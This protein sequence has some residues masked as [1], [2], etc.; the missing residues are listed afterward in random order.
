MESSEHNSFLCLAMLKK[1]IGQKCL[2]IHEN[3]YIISKACW[4]DEAKTFSQHA[5]QIFLNMF[6]STPL[7]K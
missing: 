2:Q 5:G 3:M 7:K 4:K 6:V 1:E